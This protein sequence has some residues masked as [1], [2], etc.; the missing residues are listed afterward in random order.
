MM[1]A[2][3]LGDLEGGA[4]ALIDA[5]GAG[6]FPPRTGSGTERL[7]MVLRRRPSILTCVAGFCPLFATSLEE[8]TD[9]DGREP[10][11][12]SVGEG[13]RLKDA[14]DGFFTVATDIFEQH[15]QQTIERVYSPN[16][17]CR[18]IQSR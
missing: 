5:F 8:G 17:S 12:D 3:G 14:G 11:E 4:G 7:F 2:G 16:L 13:S 15:C 10:L 18:L 1:M 9:L 6:S